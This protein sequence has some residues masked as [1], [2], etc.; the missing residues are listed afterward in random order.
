[1]HSAEEVG[2]LGSLKAHRPTGGRFS[3]GNRYRR[4]CWLRGSFSILG[5]PGF[6]R[7]EIAQKRIC[8]VDLDEF[9]LG[10]L[11]QL[12]IVTKTI[13][14]PFLDPFAVN[15]LDLLRTR[16]CSALEYFVAL[17][18]SDLHSTAPF[19][20]SAPSL[21]PSNR[22][23]RHPHQQQPGKETGRSIMPPTNHG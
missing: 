6:I 23:S 4:A 22:D 16:I 18:Q 12:R 1:M 10:V 21:S 8:L 14:M 7:G 19:A 11:L 9:F 13:V 15:M 2:F 3:W 20:V 5:Y 17:L